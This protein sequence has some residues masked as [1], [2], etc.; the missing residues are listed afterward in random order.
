M[1]GAS[2]HSVINFLNFRALSTLSLA[3]QKAQNSVNAGKIA[4]AQ[5]IQA[6]AVPVAVP[7]PAVYYG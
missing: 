3:T 6:S 2:L 4:G 1:G 7:A 5:A